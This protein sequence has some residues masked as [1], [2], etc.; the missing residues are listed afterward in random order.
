AL[1]RKDT[2]SSDTKLVCDHVCLFVQIQR[3]V[4]RYPLNE[5]KLAVQTHGLQALNSA[6]EMLCALYISVIRT[7]HDNRP[8]PRLLY[9]GNDLIAIYRDRVEEKIVSRQ[10]RTCQP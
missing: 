3:N 4:S 5:T 2:D 8:N 1:Q 9:R 10:K 6:N 7:V